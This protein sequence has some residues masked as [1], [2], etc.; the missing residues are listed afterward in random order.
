[1]SLAS[2][3]KSATLKVASCCKETHNAR[4]NVNQLQKRTFQVRNTPRVAIRKSITTPIF[5]V[6]W[7]C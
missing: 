2:S 6:K 3:M 5:T 1:M 7:S 4:H